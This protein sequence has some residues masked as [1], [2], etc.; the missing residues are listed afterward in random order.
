VLEQRLT[1]A[2]F[3]DVSVEAV[4]SPLRLASAAECVRFERESFGALHQ[5][6][7]GVPEGERE[8]VWQEIEDALRRFESADG[9]VGPC[10]LLVVTAT[11]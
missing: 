1:D 3:G 10:E 4:P 5:M 11:K 2:G 9:F 7:A 6:L 8:G